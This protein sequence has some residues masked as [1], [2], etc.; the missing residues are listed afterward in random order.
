MQFK[1]R[2]EAG[3]L[4]AQKL[5]A[6][7]DKPDVLVLALPRGGVPVAV[8]VAQV[9]HAPV[10]VFLVRKL[11]A[12]GQ[13][14]LALGA[15]AIGGVRVLNEA[16]MRSLQITPEELNAVTATEQ[17]ELERR[18]HAYRDDRP[19]PKIRGRTIILV[20]DGLATGASMLAAI[21]ALRQQHPARIVVGV[22]AA[23]SDVC[24]EFQ[25]EVDEIVCAITPYPFYAVG[26]W[27]EDFSQ[28]DDDEVRRLL[29]VAQHV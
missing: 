23:S 21:L 11:G 10:D 29:G 20:D 3:R 22:P 24:R 12:P 26:A 8:E 4:L 7:R 5:L 28:V 2:A 14:E 19:L 15:V 6:Y 27:Y 18:Q 1:D 17:R 13:E 16:V 25:H 9:L